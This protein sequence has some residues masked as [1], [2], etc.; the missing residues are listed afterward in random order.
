MAFKD[1]R[2]VTA[3]I[4][5]RMGSSRFEAKTLADLHGLPMLNRQI[6]RIRKSDYIDSVVVAT[7]DLPADQQI[8][9]WCKLNDVGCYRGSAKDVLGRLACAARTF[10]MTNIVEVLGDNPLVHADMIDAAV[11][12][13]FEK[14]VDY[15]ATLTNEYPKAAEGLK[16]F[17][18]GIRVQV[19][20]ITTLVRCSELAKHDCHREHA[21]SYIAE[22]PNLFS[23]VFVEAVEHFST[24]N[25]PELT[26]AVN[27]PKNLELIRFIYKK[28]Y[29]N[30]NNFTVQDAIRLF[31][32]TPALKLLMGNQ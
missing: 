7:T 6:E 32:S 24:C 9:D 31:D 29:D 15:V 30:N 25:R 10:N 2:H 28:S 13:Y 26:F 5:A 17:P 12:L 19:F 14:N 1:R 22:N 16:K 3:L 23:T 20:S 11:K 21:T 8:E 27:L 4:A 18:I